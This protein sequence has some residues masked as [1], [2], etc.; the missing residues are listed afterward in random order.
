MFPE[1]VRIVDELRPPFFLME[2]VPGLAHRHNYGLLKTIFATFKELGYRS[3]ADVL[4]AAHYGVPQLRYRFFMIG[5]LTD[6]ALTLPAPTHA[7]A[8]AHGLFSKPFVT[9]W[10]AIGDLPEPGTD[11]Q[12]CS[13][14]PYATP[15]PDNEFQ[16]YAR[17]GSDCVLNHFCSAT[18]QI[19][20]DRAGHVPE[21]GNWK[22][23]P[24]ELLPDRFFTCRMTDH[25]TTYAR[26]RRDMP[27]YTI[28]ALFGNITAGAFTH[29]LANRSL[30]VRE[31]ARLQSFRDTFEFCGPRNSQYRQIGNAVPPLLSRAVGTHIKALIET[32]RVGGLKPRITEAVLADGTA[33][34]ALP[35]LT[36]RFKE[37]F[38]SG[39]RWPIGWGAEPKDRASML[40][41]NYSLRPEFWPE[42]L[43]RTRK[44]VTHSRL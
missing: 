33:W 3:A 38:G 37:T 7:P 21:G 25:S 11:T 5:T 35:I 28:T 17:Q 12:H 26:L 14:L 1:F 15:R 24:R 43:A 19:N 44:R 29:P 18:Q 8:E 30:S 32:E 22:D 36:P 9:T 13:R 23:I 40:D 31:G 39:T 34:D 16:E 2:N 42:H 27:S 6:A 10:D 4:L 41:S 20:L